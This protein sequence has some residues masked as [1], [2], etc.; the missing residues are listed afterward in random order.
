MGEEIMLVL[1][2]IN[3]CLV[4]QKNTME[5]LSG[6]LLERMAKLERKIDLALNLDI[7]PLKK[8]ST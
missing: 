6:D 8:M 5:S 1:K 7:E 3:D 4:D 2:N